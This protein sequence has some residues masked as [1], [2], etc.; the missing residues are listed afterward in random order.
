ML[1][2]PIVT[3]SPVAATTSSSRG[4]GCGWI[5]FA[6]ASSRLVSPA[7]AEGTTTPSCP[8]ARHLA[9]RRATFRIR[10]TEPT[11][12]PPYFWTINAMG[13]W[14]K[15]P[16]FTGRRLEQAVEPEKRHRGR[17]KREHCCHGGKDG[18]HLS[19][20]LLHHQLGVQSLV[21]FLQIGRVAREKIFAARHVGNHLER[22][23]V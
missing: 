11:E 23:L 9:P 8:A 6:S 12:V 5:S 2:R 13:A 20:L 7:M 3:C 4:S 15:A 21:D 16:D 19:L 22:I 14:R 10:S 1:R 17:E 18:R